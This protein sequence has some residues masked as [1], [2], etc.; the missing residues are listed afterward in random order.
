M[1]NC[2]SLDGLWKT[3]GELQSA[4]LRMMIT[5]LETGVA[6]APRTQ[7]AL[8]MA[9]SI[10]PFFRKVFTLQAVFELEAGE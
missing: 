5:A 4:V 8:N 1:L 3:D 7:C 10:P 6:A 9:V 2:V